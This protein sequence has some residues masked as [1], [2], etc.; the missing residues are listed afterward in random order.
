MK[1]EKERRLSVGGGQSV[2]VHGWGQFRRVAS[3]WGHQQGLWR[4]QRGRCR[5]VQELGQVY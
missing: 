4:G 2:N 1:C 3:K 5:G